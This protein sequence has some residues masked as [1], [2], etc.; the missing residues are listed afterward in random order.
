MKVREVR[1][2]LRSNRHAWGRKT[3]RVDA[4]EDL[5]W[6][7]VIQCLTARKFCVRTYGRVPRNIQEACRNGACNLN[8]GFQE[9]S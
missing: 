8:R 4:L 5:M 1:K 9:E 3:R 2:L 7:G 6:G